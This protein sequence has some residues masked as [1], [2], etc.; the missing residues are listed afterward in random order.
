MRKSMLF[1]MLMLVS[2]LLHAEANQAENNLFKCVD[3]T[4]LTLNA[5]CLS[6]TIEN[7]MQFKSAQSEFNAGLSDLGGNVMATMKFYPEQM[8]IQIIAHDDSSEFSSLAQVKEYQDQ[9]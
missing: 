4:Q 1:A 6:T 3:N 8:L 5:D 2:A 7:G 9:N